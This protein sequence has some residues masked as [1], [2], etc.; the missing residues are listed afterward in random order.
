MVPVTVNPGVCPRRTYEAAECAWIRFEPCVDDSDCAINLKCC[1]NGCGLQCIAP[2][3][4]G[5]PQP[6][7]H[8]HVALSKTRVRTEMTFGILKARFNCLRRS[9]VSPERASLLVDASA[10][11]QNKAIIRKEKSQITSSLDPLFI[12]DDNLPA[13]RHWF[14]RNLKST[15]NS[16]GIP[17]EQFSS[18]SFRIGAATTAAQRGLPDHQIK[19]LGRWSSQAFETYIT[20]DKHNK[21]LLLSPACFHLD[22]MGAPPFQSMSFPFGRRGGPPFLNRCVIFHDFN[23]GGSSVRIAVWALIRKEDWRY[24]GS[25]HHRRLELPKRPEVIR[26]QWKLAFLSCKERQIHQCRVLGILS[27]N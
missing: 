17:T 19:M 14:Q 24:Q 10:I 21:H 11:L 15:L 20:L 13:S 3:Y 8:L 7:N 25:S 27:V 23:H 18:H 12:D 26:F 6:R 2:V 1:N 4:Y 9:R 22:A 16:S 5:L